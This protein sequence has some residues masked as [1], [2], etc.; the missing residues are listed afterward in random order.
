MSTFSPSKMD[1]QD[2]SK[3][4]Q[5]FNR[6]HGRKARVLVFLAKGSDPLNNDQ[7]KV[8][9]NPGCPEVF[10]IKNLLIKFFIKEQQEN[11]TQIDGLTK[12]CD[13]LT[14]A[15]EK[16]EILNKKLFV[17]TIRNIEAKLH[18]LNM[19]I[20]W[21]DKEL[22]KKGLMHSS[23]MW[24]MRMFKMLEHRDPLYDCSFEELKGWYQ[25]LISELVDILSKDSPKKI[26]ANGIS[27]ENLN[28]FNLMHLPQP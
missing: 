26:P 9:D 20:L 4:M 17:E 7:K 22:S 16:C 18:G 11:A 3:I 14:L 25:Y 5:F 1:P 15:M 13:K 21:K 19:D 6:D 10:D 28:S 24:H 27:I 23:F 12:K 8:L 2:F